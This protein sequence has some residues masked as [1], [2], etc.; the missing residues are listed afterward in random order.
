M[1]ERIVKI[2]RK[3]QFF[4]TNPVEQFWT[5]IALLLIFI[6]FCI[7][8]STVESD[9]ATLIQVVF[10]NMVIVFSFLLIVNFLLFLS[11]STLP[12]LWR[13]AYRA[14]T[15]LNKNFTYKNYL[16]KNKDK[17]YK[18]PSWSDPEFEVIKDLKQRI[19]AFVQAS[20][21]YQQTDFEYWKKQTIG[22]NLDHSSQTLIRNLTMLGAGFLSLGLLMVFVYWLGLNVNYKDMGDF[23]LENLKNLINNS[24]GTVLIGIITTFIVSPVIYVVWIFRDANTR[25]QIEN[26]RKDTNLKDF[27]KLSEWA[28]GFHLPEIKQII[29]TKTAEKTKENEPKETNTENLSS[30]E[31]FLPSES[32]NSIT[33]R[34]GAEALQASAIA[35][36]EAFMFGKYGEQFMQPAFLLLHAIWIAIIPQHKQDVDP[37]EFQESLEQLHNNPIIS[38][39]NTA[40]AGANG[41]H[42]RI[43]E[44]NL[45]GLDL[46]GIMTRYTLFNH[47]T[48][49]G[50]KMTG[51][52]FNYANLSAAN[53]IGAKLEFA[54]LRNANLQN[55]ELQKCSFTLADLTNADLRQSDMRGTILRAAWLSGANFTDT[56]INRHTLF[57]QL[58]DLESR[59]TNII[60]SNEIREDVLS[61]GAIWDDD[62]EWLV[63]K[64]QDAALLEKIRQDCADRA[65]QKGA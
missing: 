55:S 25:V 32:S 53:L 63:G 64:I 65:K 26:S 43:F 21:A 46:R 5:H 42:L 20:I 24:R 56:K 6:F 36:L 60:N 13:D 18:G 16:Y 35:Q 49:S 17:I 14:I 30:R 39:L 48:L 9:Q 54:K 40:L 3:C 1:K 29:S 11:L 28:S 57:G 27:Q 4:W 51:I 31:D 34:Q 44:D 12:Y 50:C 22:V 33:R 2:L 15:K 45:E 58:K 52:N 10:H 41:Y 23:N 19:N 61:R 37:I 8:N 59:K 38:A 47:I 7:L 62:P